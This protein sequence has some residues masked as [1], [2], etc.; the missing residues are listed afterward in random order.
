MTDPFPVQSILDL[1]VKYED[2]DH[3][4]LEG[5]PWPCPTVEAVRE[6]FED[7]LQRIANLEAVIRSL[8][9]QVRERDNFIRSIMEN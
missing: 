5:D 9:S 1:H 6:G 7:H 4:T 2:S 8:E 3:C